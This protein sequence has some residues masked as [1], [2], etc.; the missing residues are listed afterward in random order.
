MKKKFYKSYPEDINKLTDDQFTKMLSY[1]DALSVGQKVAINTKAISIADADAAQAAA[2]A[3]AVTTAAP[4]IIGLVIY[5]F[6]IPE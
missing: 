2:N 5:I 3:T 6:P 4:A 1:Y